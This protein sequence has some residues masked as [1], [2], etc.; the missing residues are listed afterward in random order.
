M[1][2][3]IQKKTINATKWSSITEICVKFIQ[4]ISNM[5]L[6]RILMPKAFAIVATINMV[7]SFADIFTDAG[8]QKYIVQREYDSE[9]QKTEIIDVAF[10]TNLMLSSLLWLVIFVFRMPVAKLV[11]HSELANGI[12]IASLALPLTSFSSIQMA[13]FKRRFDFRTLFFSR[14]IGALIPL[15]ITVPLALAGFDY[16]SIIIGT[17]CGRLFDAVYL[18]LCSI[19]KPSFY[20]S[21]K[22][23]REMFGFSVWTL[24]ESITVWLTIWVGVF[25]V[26]HIMDDYHSGLYNTG[27]NTVNG[28]MSIVVGATTSVLFVSLSRLQNDTEEYNKLF[29]KFQRMVAMLVLPMGIGIFVY[30]KEI[31]K[32]LLGNQ[33]DEVSLLLGIWGLIY[34]FS[35]IFGNLVSEV[36]RSKGKPKLSVIAQLLHL[37]VLIP[38]CYF[39]AK[40]SFISLSIWRPLSRLEFIAVHFI[41]MYFVFGMSPISMIKNILP[42]LVASSFMGIIGVVFHCFFSSNIVLYCSM[43]LCALVYILILYLMKSTRKEMFDAFK[44]IKGNK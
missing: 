34:S 10:W 36:Y 37:V 25:I 29:L 28:I 6:A 5:I 42:Y 3:S 8:F 11:G 39:S 21:F 4:P 9:K 7:V 24:V 32:I 17:L 35:I 22:V 30:R 31:T 16:W 27:I 38:V 33:W 18:T 44:M 19:W 23:L 2:N 15:I 26:G 13:V 20:Y 12:V 40:T 14:L 43:F 1:S 41:I